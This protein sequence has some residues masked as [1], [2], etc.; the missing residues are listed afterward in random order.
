[1][2]HGCEGASTKEDLVHG[3]LRAAPAPAPVFTP[4]DPHLTP[5]N[6]APLLDN[7]GAADA[8]AGEDDFDDEDEVEECS[9]GIQKQQQCLNAT[10]VQ[11]LEEIGLAKHLSKFLEDLLQTSEGMAILFVFCTRC[12]KWE[13]PEGVGAVPCP[14]RPPR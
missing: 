2:L 12:R 10:Q 6:L 9:C 7:A 4:N 11:M 1:M 3:L 13:W 14:P 8:G 5:K